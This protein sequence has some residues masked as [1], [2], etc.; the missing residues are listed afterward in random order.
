MTDSELYI[1]CFLSDQIPVSEWIGILR[2]RPDVKV[3]FEERMKKKYEKIINDPIMIFGAPRSGTSWLGQIFNSHPDVKFCYQP[4]F[5]YEFKSTLS[6]DSSEGEIDCFFKKMLVTDN[7]FIL[8]KDQKARGVHP[9]FKKNKNPSRLA[10]KHVRYHYLIEHFL[11]IYKNVKI[12]GIIRH[13]CGV[14]NSWLKTPREFKPS[15]NM[16]E[17]RSGAIKNQ[18][19]KEEYNG[20]EKWKEV[21]RLF[22][23][24]EEEYPNNFKIFRYEDLTLNKEEVARK[25]FKFVNLDI[26]N[27]T[28]E[29]LAE[30]GE[31]EIEDPDTAYRI[32]DVSCRWRD[33]LDERIIDEIYDDLRG[34]DL[35][36]FLAFERA[37]E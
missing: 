22:I 15:W 11:K 13:P 16:D 14:I 34:T 37:H 19:K 36:V 6:L 9:I 20:F 12:I 23:R 31:K 21:S 2:E 29:F 7:D 24:L 32:P 28:I 35:D 3:A 1:D 26:S 5:S 27:N 17:W 4:L 18:D 30:S 33:E 8:Q 10:I 25:M